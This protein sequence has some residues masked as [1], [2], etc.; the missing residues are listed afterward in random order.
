M[1]AKQPRDDDRLEEVRRRVMKWRATRSKLGPM[2]GE[3]WT[4]AVVLARDQ[5]ASPLDP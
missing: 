1:G 3:L 4:A 2:P 5:G